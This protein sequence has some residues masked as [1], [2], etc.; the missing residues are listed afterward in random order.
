MTTTPG[1]SRQATTGQSATE[2]ENTG[3]RPRRIVGRWLL[4]F[5]GFPIG[6]Y[7]AALLVGPLDTISAA[8]V[9]GLIA[10]AVLGGAQAWALGPRRPRPT[11]W[12]A[13]TA[14]G[15]A[16][17][18]AL[19]SA[20]VD[21]AT[22]VDALLVQGAVTGAVVGL[23]QAVVLLPRLRGWALLWPVALSGLWALGWL[24]TDTVIGTSV[25]Q[26][27]YVFGSSGALT[28][29]ALTS[30]LPLALSRRS[31]SNPAHPLRRPSTVTGVDAS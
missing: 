21:Y 2:V 14:V 19:G 20:A 10:G 9:G 15:L 17:G 29:T 26:Q 3:P 11:S 24:V 5:L 16:A 7:V 22:H 4:S 27:F 8:L 25:D 13:A 1:R 30:A 31:S 28:V 6:G 12:V 18:V 23:A